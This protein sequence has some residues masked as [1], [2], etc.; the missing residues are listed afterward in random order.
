MT[1]PKR[2]LPDLLPRDQSLNDSPGAVAAGPIEASS[3]LPRKRQ[4]VTVACKACRE[5][6]MKC[7]GARPQCGRCRKGGVECLFERP[8]DPGPNKTPR[9]QLAKYYT[10]VKLLYEGTLAESMQTLQTLRD[11]IDVEHAVDSVLA[12]R[13]EQK[14]RSLAELFVPLQDEPEVAARET[15][16][17]I[18]QGQLPEATL[19]SIGSD[20]SGRISPSLRATN[21]TLL[22]PTQTPLGF[23]LVVEHANVYPSL[24][25]LDPA[26]LDLRS[27]G[28][29]PLG[30]KNLPRSRVYE[31]AGNGNLTLSVDPKALIGK[32]TDSRVTDL[33]DARL[34]QLNVSRWTHIPSGDQLAAE[35]ISFDSKTNQPWWSFFDTDL[36]LD[37][38]LS[39]QTNFGS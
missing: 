15:L 23:R 1:P 18:R 14:S 33:A 37:D 8:L 36:F 2:R 10:V 13:S 6:K 5:R 25:P 26:S 31:P 24:V 27:L 16:G 3:Y 35:A 28:M 4:A 38:S 21:W 11:S 17:A 9:A 29:G 20:T 39:E 32:S 22:P 7:D 30:V 34:G 19:R 12:A